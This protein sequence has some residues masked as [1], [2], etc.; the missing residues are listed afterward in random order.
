MTRPVRLQL[1]RLKGFSLQSWSRQVNG[2]EAENCARPGKWG[3]P[4]VVGQPSGCKFDD[5]GDP[6]PMIA[7][8]TINQCIE[9]YRDLLNGFV[10]PEM[11]PHGH[12]WMARYRKQ[13]G[14]F[15]PAYGMGSLRS[16]NLACFCRLCPNH[17]ATGKPL[18]EHCPDCAPCHV[19]VLGEIVCEAV[20]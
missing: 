5:G 18:D 7:S 1:S 9:F 14:H 10:N 12:K 17:A 2:L 13:T 15:H 11:H 3:N 6:T 4:F 19:D 16:K 20:G 8:L